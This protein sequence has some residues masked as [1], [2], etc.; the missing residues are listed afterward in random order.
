MTYEL[1]TALAAFA[2]VASIT[3]GPNNLMVM[4]SGANFGFRRTMPHWFGIIIGFFIMVVLVGMGLMRMFA[5]YPV[6]YLILKSA[7]VAY[8]LFLAWKV[9]TAA[10]L[11]DDAPTAGKPFT[12]LQAALFQWVNPKAWAMALSA[13]S[14]YTPPSHPLSSVFVVA[15]VFMLANLPSQGAWIL[16]GMQLRRFLDAPVKLRVFNVS[17]AVLLI[18]SLY[19]ILFTQ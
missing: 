8:L 11:N 1:T 9:A 15:I 17:M 12:L 19:P 14:A 3:P 5:A 6:T 16:L 13:I 4:A 7:S 18:A 10:P 2:L